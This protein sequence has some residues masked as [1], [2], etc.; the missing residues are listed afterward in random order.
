MKEGLIPMKKK[1]EMK[2]KKAIMLLMICIALEES[3]FELSLNEDD[4]NSVN[5]FDPI[6]DICGCI[7]LKKNMRCNILLI[8]ERDELPSQSIVKEFEKDY[9][10]EFRIDCGSNHNALLFYYNNITV[11]ENTT[12]HTFQALIMNAVITVLRFRKFEGG[13]SK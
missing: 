12:M 4:E 8:D 5:F 10:S 13:F 3:K 1:K 2:S 7:S 11:P 9:H 6:T